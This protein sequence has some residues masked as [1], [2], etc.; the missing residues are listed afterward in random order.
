MIKYNSMTDLM[1]TSEINHEVKQQTIF[2]LYC[3][4]QHIFANLFDNLD[5]FAENE[6]RI[7]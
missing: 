1:K 2:L 7:I 6:V 4:I 5:Y 3:I